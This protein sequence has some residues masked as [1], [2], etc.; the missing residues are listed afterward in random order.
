MFSW[1]SRSM[2]STLLPFWA[3]EMAQGT[4]PVPKPQIQ[5]LGVEGLGD[6][7]LGDLGRGAQ[8]VGGLHGQLVECLCRGGV[9]ARGGQACHAGGGD[10]G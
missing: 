5:D 2:T 8:P 9:G 7:G 1:A 10:G 4:P 3:A 6:V